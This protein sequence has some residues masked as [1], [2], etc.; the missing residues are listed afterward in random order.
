MKIVIIGGVA[1]GATAAARLRRMDEHAAI[2][3]YEKGTDISY[4]NCGLPYYIGRNITDRDRL[5]LQT[6]ESFNARFNVAVKVLHEVT[7]IDTTS[8]TVTVLNLATNETIVDHFDK[9]L[10]STG[11]IGRLPQFVK[12]EKAPVFGL[13][14]LADMDAIDHYINQEQPKR[15]IVVGAGFIGLEMAENLVERGLNVTIVQYGK[16]ILGTVDYEMACILHNDLRTLGVNL[17][18]DAEVTAMELHNNTASLKLKSGESI[19]GDLILVSTGIAPNAALAKNAGITLGDQGGI[20]VNEYMQTSSPDVYAVGDVAEIYHRIFKSKMLVPLAGPANKQARIAADNMILGN[21]KKYEGAIGTSILKLSTLTAASVG[22]TE[23]QLKRFNISFF[24][25]M[26]HGQSHASYYPG[27]QPISLKINY[28]PN[29]GL[30]LGA[31]V[32]GGA[33]VD[34]RIDMLATIMQNGGTI[35]DLAELEHAYAPPY[36]SAKD[37]VNMIGFVAENKLENLVKTISHHELSDLLI[38]EN[39]LL[40]DVRTSD[41]FEMGH[42][43]DA[44][45]FPLDKMRTQL[46]QLSKDKMIIVYCQ[47]GLRGYVAARMLTQSGF[48]KVYNLSGGYKTYASVQ[49][50]EQAIKCTSESI[51]LTENRVESKIPAVASIQIDACGLQC[52]G[53]IMKLK[54]AYQKIKNGQSLSIVV[55]DPGFVEDVQGWSKMMG[56]SVEH[57]DRDNGKFQVIIKKTLLPETRDNYI[58]IRDNKTIIVFS[59]DFDKVFASLII[60]NGA[61]AAGK[62][63]TLF[64]TFWGLSVIRKMSTTTNKSFL[65]KIFG[66]MLPNSIQQLSLS[67]MNMLG[68]APKMMQ[69]VMKKKNVQS[70]QML[71]QNLLNNGAEL[72]ACS[73]SMEVMGIQRAEL[74]DEVKIAGVAA[75]LERSEQAN[76]NL[77]I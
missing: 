41:E 70:L 65:D 34:A 12:E 39:T 14:T 64:F 49:Q 28:A 59:N 61:I 4:A 40:L 47:V 22:G 3:I 46:T 71:L 55:T 69:Y 36:S 58:P 15:A 33:G 32:V 66:K 17:I 60:A 51:V 54:D 31:Q 63:V 29:S 53:P 62:K 75:Y 57:I 72:I 43:D 18:L 67:K 20:S 10:I 52:P 8:K 35:Y 76:M 77:F 24:T 19:T 45:N 44:L 2:T 50:S 68:M 7:A 73:M 30:L 5:L 11:A 6:P 48:P 26:I 21:K 38:S 25:D 23:E 74:I 9:L 13:R 42:I 27:S 37:P 16:Q 1:G 56:A